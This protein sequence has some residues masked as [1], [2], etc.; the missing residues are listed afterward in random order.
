M[1]KQTIEEESL[2]RWASF[3]GFCWE[4]KIALGV[5]G[6]SVVNSPPANAG[7]MSS[8]PKL[9]RSPGEGNENPVFLPGKSHGQRSLVGYSPW[10]CKR[11]RHNSVTKWQQRLSCFFSLFAFCLLGMK[12]KSIP[13][14]TKIIYLFLVIRKPTTPNI[15]LTKHFKVASYFYFAWVHQ[16]LGLSLWL[17]GEE[18][19]W[20]AGDAGDEGLIL[21]SGS[22]PGEGNGNPLQYSRLENSMERGASWAVVQRVSKSWTWL[23]WRSTAHI[24]Y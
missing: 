16:F 17:R 22:S 7:D 11:V 5:P 12:T 20:K 9:G 8:I 10:G 13:Y 6:G 2:L 15:A 21:G 14:F 19:A 24:N 3:L 23:K 4:V 18:S 1:R